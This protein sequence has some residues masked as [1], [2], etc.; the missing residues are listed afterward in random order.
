MNH[1]IMPEQLDF[2][3]T[4]QTQGQELKEAKQKARTQQDEIY[5]LFVKH[6]AMTPFDVIEKGGYDPMQITSIRRAITNLTNA[7]K[8]VKTERVRKERLGKRNHLWRIA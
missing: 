5:D 8:L 7:G 1:V 2:F 6:R 4:N 3:N